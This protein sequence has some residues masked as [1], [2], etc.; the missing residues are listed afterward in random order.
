M[1]EETPAKADGVLWRA[2]QIET[3]LQAGML[4]EW[5]Q[6]AFLELRD[7]VRDEDFPC[8]FG[9]LA[10]KHGDILFSFVGS[11]GLDPLVAAAGAALTEYTEMLRQMDPVRGS[12]VPLAILAPPPSRSLTLDAYFELSWK[13]LNRLHQ[14]DPA[15][16]PRRVP[17][18]PE[19][20]SWSFCFGGIPLFVNFKTPAHKARRSRRMKTAFVLLVQ[21][22]DGFDILAGNTVKG[23]RARSIIR[24]KLAAYDGMAPHPALEH[25]NTPANREWQQY[26][27]PDDN[28]ARARKCPFGGHD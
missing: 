11:T 12:M 6:A 13:V 28:L 18:D 2:S 5:Q 22:R 27:L 21:A 14:R 9:T 15:E 25:Y 7:K 16:W 24:E 8:T 23:R 3:R 17:P 1:L 26:F 10:E 19:S 4:P 20:P